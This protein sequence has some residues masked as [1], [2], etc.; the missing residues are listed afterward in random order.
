MMRGSEEKAALDGWNGAPTQR[1]NLAVLG[2]TGVGKSTLIN[3]VFGR[4]VAKTG[5]G[6]PVTKGVQ[7]HASETLGLYDFEGAESFE[8]LDSFVRNFKQ[9]YNERIVEDSDSA[10]HVIWYCVKA[11][12]RR[13]D[14]HQE[15]LL[16][17]FREMSLPVILVVT[18][19]PWRPDHGMDPS[20]QAFLDHLNERQLPV[21]AILPVSAVDDPYAGTKAFGLRE[22][23]DATNDAAPEGVRQALAAAQHIDADFKSREARK[24]VLA[25][26]AAAAAV[27]TIPVPVADAPALVALQ[28]GMLRQIAQI[29]DL[30]LTAKGAVSVLTGSLLTWGGKTLAGQLA[31]LV[32]G[33]GSVINATVAGTLTAILGTAWRRLCESDWRGDISV[34]NLMAAGKLNTVFSDYLRRAQGSYPK[35]DVSP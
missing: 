31:K 30:K 15:A 5:I 7:F 35:T 12:D 6:R 1:F 29:Y 19:T 8:E 28:F 21:H 33:A 17:H 14:D 3:A 10:V 24:V 32:P 13:F 20:A 11:S 22:L 4:E 25:A 23:L 2:A 34:S 27:A 16:G 26:S 18:Q 9:I